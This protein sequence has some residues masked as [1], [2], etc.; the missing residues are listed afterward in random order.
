MSRLLKYFISVALSNLVFVLSNSAQCVKI[1]DKGLNRVIYT[2]ADVMPQFPGGTDA[3]RRYGERNFFLSENAFEDC[4]QQ[5]S[6]RYS[7][8]VETNGS[9][10]NIIISDKKDTSLLCASEKS[11]Y[12]FLKTIPKWN[13]GKCKNKYVA[14]KMKMNFL[15]EIQD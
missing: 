7:M 8:I 13:P 1:Y 11:L 9:L 15:L 4:G 5:L 2:V 10:S 14:V 3:W 12:Y 6:I